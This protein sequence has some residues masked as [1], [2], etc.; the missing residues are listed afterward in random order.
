METTP[1]PKL[2]HQIKKDK[3]LLAWI[4]LVLITG[5][6]AS[7]L[8]Y[9]YSYTSKISID[10]AEISA[11]KIDLAAK[12]PGTL[13]ETFV[14]E[15]DVVAADTVV[16]RVGT[17]LIKTDT[18]GTII[19]VKKNVGTIFPAGTPV[20]SMIESGQLK[21]SG[22]LAEDKG[23]KDV[24]IGQTASFTVDAFGG[25]KYYGIVDEI[26]PTSRESGVSF[27]IS[28]KRETKEFEIKIR[29]DATT[30]PELKNGMSAKISIYKN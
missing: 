6:V 11:N 19:T 21:V 30:Y 8:V 27:S 23:L 4:I 28:D 7:G 24:R 25:K 29:F 13:E 10:K 16:A 3:H 22:R 1:K 9:F 18:A 12:T 26:S 5:A 20:V 2:F 15:G 14:N 17:T